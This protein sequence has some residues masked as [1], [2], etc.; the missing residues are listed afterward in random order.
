MTRATLAARSGV[1]ESYIQY[2]EERSSATPTAATVIQLAAALAT[3]REELLGGNVERAPGRAVPAAHPR[4]ETMT[5]EECWT[6]LGTHGVGRIVFNGED[7]PLAV[8]LNYSVAGTDVVVSTA[9]DTLV[10]SL[11]PHSTVSF[12]VDHIDDAM[13]EGWSILAVGS[14]EHEGGGAPESAATAQPWA[15]PERDLRRRI[16]CRTI[17]GRRIQAR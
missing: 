12:E 16:A 15:G 1:S 5:E 7:G 4:L 11:A 13:S 17:S 6:L 8:P 3:T 14:L 10:A 9:P 2:L